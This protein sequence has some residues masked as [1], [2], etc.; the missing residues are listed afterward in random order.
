M[1]SSCLVLYNLAALEPAPPIAHENTMVVPKTRFD[2]WAYQ[3]L[4]AGGFQHT[5][6]STHVADYLPTYSP[7]HCE[8]FRVLYSE[9]KLIT[10]SML[11]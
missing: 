11:V 10:T 6:Q 8:L 3:H 1:H 4:G 5:P 2:T 7:D 9:I